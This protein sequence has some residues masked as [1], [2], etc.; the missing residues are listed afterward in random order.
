MF[1]DMGCCNNLDS[2][3]APLKEIEMVAPTTEAEPEICPL[4][5]PLTPQPPL[6]LP[7]PPPLT[8]DPDVL[9]SGQDFKNRE[10][11]MRMNSMYPDGW[12]ALGATALK[13]SAKI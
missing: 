3:L 2:F 4:R 1:D 13:V 11:A 5:R 9:T 12:F 10:S 8:D 7:K 6:A